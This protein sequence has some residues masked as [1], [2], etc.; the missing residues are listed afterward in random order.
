[1]LRMICVMAI[2]VAWVGDVFGQAVSVTAESQPIGT[3]P[4]E[5]VAQ[6]I[7]PKLIGQP[8][9][10]PLYVDFF[11]RELV[12]DA[13]L[14]AFDVAAQHDGGRRV[15]LTGYV[16]FPETH[17][18]LVDYLQSLNFEVEDRLEM[19]PAESLGEKRFGFVK[20]TNSL[21]Y[22]RPSGRRGVVTDCLL[23]EP[24][25]LLREDGKHLLVHAGEGYLGYVKSA[26]VH[27]VTG[28]EFAKYVSGPRVRIMRD[29][30]AD[31][32]RIPAGAR[33][34]LRKAGDDSIEAE[35]PTGEVV[36][37]PLKNCEVLSDQ[38]PKIDIVVA[39]AKQLI[40]TPYLW[41]G[42]TTKGCDCSGLVQI[43]YATAGLHLPR[44]S[45]QQVYLGQ[46]SAT[47]WH[48]DGLRR[49]DTLYFLGSDGK[50][51]H[52]GLYLGDDQFLQAVSP[53]VRINSFNPKD[54]NY[55]DAHFKN[56]AFAKRLID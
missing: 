8:D 49:G 2:A 42:K 24:V 12:N 43:G 55:D 11:R 31:G 32:R 13:R 6:K 34:K 21:S 33:L 3:Q 40:G 56:F 39:N 36:K 28:E 51:R 54:D 41:G 37:L 30:D 50:I 47:R 29:V 19:L 26:D 9:R 14:F 5:R 17:R 44:D 35:L 27:R 46:L 53:R 18:S 48:R 22:D 52:T 7:E 20:S 4:M 23:G 1:M 38:S 45:N 15:V 10:L 16:E 25:Y